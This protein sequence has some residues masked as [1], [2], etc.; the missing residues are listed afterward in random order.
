M[1]FCFR[2]DQY[3]AVE[4]IITRVDSK[5]PVKHFNPPPTTGYVNFTS[6]YNKSF[7]EQVSKFYCGFRK[8]LW[9]NKFC[10]FLSV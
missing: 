4:L 9:C 5:T 3:T 1:Y 8:Y 7:M 2:A 6:M 10:Y